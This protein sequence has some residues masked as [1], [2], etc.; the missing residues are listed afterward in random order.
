GER[1]APLDGGATPLYGTPTTIPREVA[2]ALDPG[3]Q[4]LPVRSDNR[5]SAP[6]ISNKDP[7]TSKKY[8]PRPPTA[9]T[10]TPPATPGQA[11]HKDAQERFP[12]QLG[13]DPVITDDTSGQADEKSRSDSK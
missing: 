10:G 7:K 9:P 6:R 1:P 2:G 11:A 3:S 5:G 8:V 4:A 13:K 12:L